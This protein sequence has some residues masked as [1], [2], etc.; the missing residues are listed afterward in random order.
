MTFVDGTEFSHISTGV[1]LTATQVGPR[2][3]P[4]GLN[5]DRA[6]IK[7]RESNLKPIPKKIQRKAEIGKYILQGQ[8]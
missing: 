2:P 5:T 7:E 6:E 3:R 4:Q 8:K 1:A